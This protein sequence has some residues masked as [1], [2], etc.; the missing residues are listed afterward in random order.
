MD[1]YPTDIVWACAVAADRINNGYIKE[2]RWDK[3]DLLDELVEK[4]SNKRL[5]FRF[6]D[7]YRNGTLVVDDND[8]IEGETIRQYWQYQT[9]ILLDDTSNDYLRSVVKAAHKD[10]I[11]GMYDV[12]IINSSIEA[13]R[14]DI[15]R[16]EIIDIKLNLNSKNIYKPGEKFVLGKDSDINVIT[17]RYIDKVGSSVVECIIDGNLYTWWSNRKLSLGKYNYIRAKVK[18]LEIDRDTNQPNTKLYYVRATH[19]EKT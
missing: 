12:A 16:R 8:R 15:Q 3:D 9:M 13:R 18:S 17:S 11:T 14:R 5:V 7:E 10:T 19:N 6:L 2:S 4:P 1:D